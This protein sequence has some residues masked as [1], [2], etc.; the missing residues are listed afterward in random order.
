MQNTDTPFVQNQTNTVNMPE[1]PSRQ[2]RRQ[3]ERRQSK[4]MRRYM[5]ETV[6]RR[7]TKH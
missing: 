6:L 4:E 3:M 2:T 1:A 5:N 7:N